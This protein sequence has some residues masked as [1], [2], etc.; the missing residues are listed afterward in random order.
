MSNKIYINEMSSLNHIQNFL[1]WKNIRYTIAMLKMGVDE[2]GKPTKEYVSLSKYRLCTTTSATDGWDNGINDMVLDSYER[3]K[4]YW[5][6]KVDEL[7]FGKKGPYK[8][9]Y[10]IDTRQ[11]YVLDIDKISAYKHPFVISVLNTKTPSFKSTSKNLDKLF[12]FI[13]KMPPHHNNNIPLLMD[14][15]ETNKPSLEIQCGQWS[16][17][18]MDTIISNAENDIYKVDVDIIDKE[19]PLFKKNVKEIQKVKKV[20]KE[21]IETK[22]IEETKEDGDVVVLKKEHWMELFGH[23]KKEYFDDYTK[24]LTFVYM[25]KSWDVNGGGGEDGREIIHHFSKTYKKYDKIEVNNKYDIQNDD[26][27]F[28]GY[29]FNMCKEHK[30]YIFRKEEETIMEDLMSRMTHM[31]LIKFIIKKPWIDRCRYCLT[32]KKWYVCSEVNNLWRQM[33]PTYLFHKMKE[34]TDYIENVKTTTKIKYFKDIEKTNDKTEKKELSKT[35]KNSLKTYNQYLEKLENTTFLNGVFKGLQD[36]RAF[37]NVFELLDTNSNLLTFIDGVFDADKNIFRDVVP[38]DMITMCI[39]YK[40]GLQK[41]VEF[42]K[43]NPPPLDDNHSIIIEFFNSL[44]DKQEMT[45]YILDIIC[46]YLFGNNERQQMDILTGEGSNGKSSLMALLLKTF[47]VYFIDVDP[48]LLTKAKTSVNQHGMMLELKGKKLVVAGEPKDNEPILSHIL[49]KLTGNDTITERA[50]YA[51]LNLSYTPFFGV[52]LMCNTQPRLDKVGY[53]EERRINVV[54]FPYRFLTP[55]KRANEDDQKMIKDADERFTTDNIIK[56]HYTFM[57]FLLNRYYTRVRNIVLVRPLDVLKHSTDYM[58]DNETIDWVEQNY[59]PTDDVT[60]R[61]KKSELF[62][63]YKQA[64]I[65]S[66]TRCI[67]KQEFYRILKRA[68]YDEVKSSGFDCYKIT[69]KKD[70]PFSCFR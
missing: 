24:W 46:S 69:L 70:D 6:D 37:D 12:L 67:K 22:D 58:N 54:Y 36:L 23:F 25:M 62:D 14:T 16:F 68:G 35:Y 1:K 27:V 50:P 30:V 66:T 38:N 13:K 63:H 48:I 28:I 41:N 60:K 55:E 43:T 4:G 32:T 26:A 7:N 52:M 61:I 40:L 9:V 15:I 19:F 65:H 44:F 34:I 45:D 18:D 64:H 31:N 51:P 42:S 57:L 3:N 11:Y 33:E 49:K 21:E 8:L 53:A 29:F 39:Q 56:H 47:S 10:A 59:D 17:V 5:N 20:Q 2:K